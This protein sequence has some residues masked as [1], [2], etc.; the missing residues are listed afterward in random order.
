MKQSQFSQSKKGQSV[1]IDF[2]ISISTFIT[3]VIVF[4]GF[5]IHNTQILKEQYDRDLLELDLATLETSLIAETSESQHGL[6]SQSKLTDSR[7][8]E[9]TTQPYEELKSELNIEHD[10]KINI[11][12]SNET[13]II[14]QSK[15]SSTIF[16][17]TRYVT[18]QNT[19]ATIRFTLYG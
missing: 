11:Q 15:L 12:T 13:F 18:H 3:L 7:L 19:Y 14:G 5:Y 9:L 2:F 10:F 8:T 4:F 1:S 6:L 17:Q 16:T